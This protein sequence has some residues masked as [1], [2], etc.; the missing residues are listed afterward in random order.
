MEY[1]MKILRYGKIVAAI[2]AISFS[3]IVSATESI[4][5][6][7]TPEELKWTAVKE[8]PAGAEVTVLSGN[9]SKHEM[10]TAR[11][12]FPANYTVPAHSHAIAEYD[13]VISGTY[14][15][16]TGKVVNTEK[17]VALPAGSFAKLPPHTPHYGW[18][19][20]ETILQ[21]SGVGPWGMIYHKHG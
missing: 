2:L 18:T 19:K 11:I 16:G 6:S 12:K 17:G 15:L 8:M 5:T 21:I 10:F 14:Y 20:E 9:P 13:T 3:G 4:A 7:S 1:I